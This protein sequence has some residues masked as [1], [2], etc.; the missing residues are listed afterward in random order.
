MSGTP[1]DVLREAARILMREGWTQ[2][3]I[4]RPEFPVHP[5]CA[6]TA[7]GEARRRLHVR[8]AVVSEAQNRLASFLSAEGFAM[9]TKADDDVFLFRIFQWNDAPERTAEDVILA[10]KRAAEES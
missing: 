6:V 4:P 2:A 9:G 1:Q 3:G 5:R 8:Q 10:L 7:I